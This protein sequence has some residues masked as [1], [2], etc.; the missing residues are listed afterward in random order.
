MSIVGLHSWPTYLHE[1]VQACLPGVKSRHDVYPKGKV[2]SDRE[3]T[4]KVR[5]QKQEQTCLTARCRNQICD[6]SSGQVPIILS[7]LNIDQA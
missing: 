3:S 2:A 6:G 5:S 4:W 1:R 7:F